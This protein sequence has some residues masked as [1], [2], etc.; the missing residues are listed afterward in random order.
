MTIVDSTRKYE[1]WVK[2]RIPIIREDLK[3]KHERM[4]DD[5]FSFFRAT[6]YRW[7]QLV[8]ELCADAFNA[9]VVLSVGDLHVENSGTWRDAEGRL[10][11]G[12]N[13]FD[14]AFPLPYTN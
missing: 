11:W 9:P 3:A 4:A 6:F 2:G 13:D 8:P 12:I 7:M 5:A 10:I 14:D 1:A